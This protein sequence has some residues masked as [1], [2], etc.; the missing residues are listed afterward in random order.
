MLA[1]QFIEGGA[2]AASSA[3]AARRPVPR[4]DGR[5]ST[6]PGARA[7][8]PQPP[9]QRAQQRLQQARVEGARRQGRHQ[10]VRGGAG[11]ARGAVL[12]AG[13]QHGLHERFLVPFLPPHGA[14]AAGLG[15]GLDRLYARPGRAV[16]HAPQVQEGVHAIVVVRGRRHRGGVP[17]VVARQVVHRQRAQ[18]GGQARQQA[19]GGQ[20]RER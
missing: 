15:H 8:A 11:A 12:G 14:D 6:A 3:R 4:R 20:A 1:P 10:H 2:R 18:L 9:A 7:A 19:A 17:R 5:K 16:R 13:A